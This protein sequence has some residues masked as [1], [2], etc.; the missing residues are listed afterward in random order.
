VLESFYCPWPAPVEPNFGVAIG[1][2]YQI[3]RLAQEDFQNFRLV[4]LDKLRTQRAR[5]GPALPFVPDTISKPPFSISIALDV[6]R[7]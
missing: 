6:T 2:Q 3:F 1:E 7:C 4:S 5:Y